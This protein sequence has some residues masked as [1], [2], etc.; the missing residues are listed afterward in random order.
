M[1]ADMNSAVKL[2]FVNREP[3]LAD[4]D[5]AAR[6]GWL[7]VIFGRRRVGKTRL[8]RQWMAG[9]GGMFSQAIKGPVE[10]QVGQVFADFSERLETRIEPRG[11]EDLLETR[12]S[13]EA[14]GDLS[15]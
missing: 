4:L 3:E 14:V 10:M 6:R 11:W 13:E 1:L 9:R 12:S 8:L 2:K 15:R 5:V 7:L